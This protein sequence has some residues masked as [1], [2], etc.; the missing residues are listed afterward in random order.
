[1]K[2]RACRFLRLL[3][4]AAVLAASPLSLRAQLSMP[5]RMFDL[6]NGLHVILH[7]DHTV[8]VIGV[9]LW[10]HVGS[11]R[12]R[13]GRTG[14]AHLFEHLMFE[15]SGHV[16]LGRFDEWLEAAGGDNNASTSVDRTNYFESAPSNALDLTLFLES[17][18]M[19]FLVDSMTPAKV[20]I[21]RDVVKNERRETYENQPYGEAW[22][23]LDENLFPPGHPYHSP[24][25]GSMDDLTAATYDDV[26][27]FFRRYYIP[28]NA[29]LVIAGDINPEEARKAV[30][31]WFS[32]VPAGPPV[33]PLNAPLP[34]LTSERRL[35]AEDRVQLPRLYMAWATPAQF[36]PGNAE[37]NVL[38]LILAGGKN[39]RLYR[40]LVYDLR[41]AQDVTAFQEENELS[42]KFYIVATA[43][44]GHTL[45]ELERIIDAELGN[46][47][48]ILPDRREIARAV[49]TIQA[50]F[51]DRMERMYDRA[52]QLNAY[53][54]A[55][56][57]P[58]YF[59]EDLGRYGKLD[60]DGISAAAKKY[61]DPAVRVV[62]SVV[63]AGRK[64]L[65]AE[66][67]EGGK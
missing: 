66:P 23:L 29:S 46:L 51:V 20:D 19:A 65:A 45:G 13:A 49:N 28:S 21:Q 52:D 40:R 50:S 24:V 61:L 54:T 30:T 17:D 15:G 55:T 9:N 60:P 26:V 31:R 64:D 36:A 8:P 57:N 5:C 10:Y 18:R 58:D 38:S 59:A 11:A 34:R 53:F 22:L 1:M 33:Q 62:L 47:S 12:E 43:R 14:L 41:I 67:P 27:G 37:L 32:D 3:T 56:G 39:S 7:E 2:R 4:V 44:E 48:G 42:S 35:V 63:P 6:P 25:I 16:P